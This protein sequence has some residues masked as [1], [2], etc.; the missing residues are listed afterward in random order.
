MF[1][2]DEVQT[3]TNQHGFEIVVKL[4]DL[5]LTYFH[6]LP[7]PTVPS[8]PPQNVTVEVLNSKVRL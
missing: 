8:A 7:V 6:F 3:S 2:G 4:R 1:I 5:S